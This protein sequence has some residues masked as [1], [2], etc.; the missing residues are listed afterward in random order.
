MSTTTITT[1]SSI[2]AQAGRLFDNTATT[3]SAFC[4]RK[5]R[6]ISQ[7]Y[8]IYTER[9]EMRNLSDEMLRDLGITREQLTRE[10]NRAVNDIPAN[11]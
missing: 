6:E 8:D 1:S 5:A 11:R 2:A 4:H 9:R 7:M 10:C 3:L